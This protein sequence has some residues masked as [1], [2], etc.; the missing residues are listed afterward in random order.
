[1]LH[2]IHPARRAVG[3]SGF[4]FSN[5]ETEKQNDGINKRL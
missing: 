4:R 2:P 1:M 5:A 3:L